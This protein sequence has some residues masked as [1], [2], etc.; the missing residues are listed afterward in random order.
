MR[1]YAI[2]LLL[3]SAFTL[4]AQNLPYVLGYMGGQE[5]PIAG[6]KVSFNGGLPAATQWKVLGHDTMALAG[7]KYNTIYIKNAFEKDLFASKGYYSDFIELRW[8]MTRYEGVVTGFRVYRKV[9]GSKSDST[10]VA[11][12][13]PDVR[14]WKDEYAESN[15]IYQ[16]T[17]IASGITKFN[18][19]MVNYVEGVGFRVP[20]GR[21]YGRVNYKGGTAVKG[22]Q[23]IAETDDNF[24]GYSLKL[25]GS[26]SYLAISPPL[27]DPMYKLDTAFTFQGWFRPGSAT[28]SCLFEKGSQ[29]KLTY[30]ANKLEFKV[31]TQPAL[32]LNFPQKVDTFFHVTAMRTADSIKLVVL[33]DIDKYR[34]EKAKLTATTLANSN[35]FFIGKSSTGEFFNGWV[36]E[37]KIWHKS[38]TESSIIETAGMYIAGTESYLSSYYRMNEN[39]GNTFYDLSRNGFNFNEKH[40][41]IYKATW[42][43]KVPSSRQLAVKGLTDANGNYVISGIP[44]MTSGSLYRFIPVYGT[45]TF[46]PS[47]KLLFIGPESTSHSNIDFTD[48]ASFIVTANLYYNETRF[49]VSGVYVKIDGNTAINGEGSP[50]MSDGNGK[51][52]VDVPIGKHYLTFEKVGHE[53]ENNGRF[54]KIGLYPG[55]KFDFQQNFSIQYDILDNTLVKVVGRVV[56]GPVQAAKPIGMGRSIN[57]I[58]NATITLK[59]NHDLIDATP[60]TFPQD[61]NNEYY[62]KDSIKVAGITKYTISSTEKTKITINPDEKTGEYVVWLLP[63]KYSVESVTAGSYTFDK[64]SFTEL[65]LTDVSSFKKTAIDRVI[66]D[67]IRSASGLKVDTLYRADSLNYHQNKDFILR[68]NPSI[69]LTDDKNNQIFWERQ[70]KAKDGQIIDVVDVNGKPKTK[71]PIFI[72][73]NEYKIKISVFEEYT[74]QTTTIT[75]KV[76]VTDGIV[77]I[78]NDLSTNSSKQLYQVSKNGTLKYIFNAGLPNLTKAASPTAELD[79]Y[80][81]TFSVVAY[82]GKDQSI[83]TN[84]HPGGPGLYDWLPSGKVFRAY[85]LGGE[86]TGSNFVTLGPTNVDMILR[87]PPGSGSYAFFEKGKSISKTTTRS[88]SHGNAGSESVTFQLGAEVKVFAG[89]GVGTIT[90]TEFQHDVTIGVD[91]EE[92]WEN[93]NTTTSTI[94]TTEKWS[95]SS[96]PNFVGSVG[97]VFIGHSSNIV[98]GKSVFIDL[99]PGDGCTDCVVDNLP[100]FSIGKHIGICISP[101]FGTGFIYTQNHIENYLIPDLKKLRNSYFTND[102]SKDIYKSVITDVTDEKY[103]TKNTTGYTTATGYTGGDIYNIIIPSNW[104][105]DSLFVDSV[106]FFNK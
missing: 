100:A 55:D 45:H 28:S 89:V 84:W 51:I 44:Y 25:D 47:E 46:E 105:S 9:L 94:T 87:D 79:D 74:N 39:I 66:I 30:S 63:E 65:D 4:N 77:E 34:I 81:K 19:K 13:A 36:D 59:A 15:V 32:I 6:G 14:S 75:D 103:G 50:I 78:Q 38:F 95:T 64:N 56:G 18:Q 69:N 91:H 60:P 35:E 101:K 7:F 98:Y 80:V 17:V 21:I 62:E 85:V 29:Y 102:N 70:V 33:Y 67:T 5:Q 96:E 22:V 31:G 11:L 8:E 12:L 72:Q 2:I 82:T 68:V 58:G 1:I 53:F 86:P 71:Y 40:G 57:N 54:P 99:V 41:Y 73:R 76:P 10:S 24:R 52:S 37:V 27:N 93:G 26:A 61:L 23:V 88:I 90:E 104:A 16:Y 49:P 3:F 106:D 83:T 92:T 42:S 48:V 43:D 20:Y 97:D